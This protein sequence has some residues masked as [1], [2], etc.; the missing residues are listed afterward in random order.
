[1]SMYAIIVEGGGQRKVSEGEIITI[2]L[3]EGGEAQVGKT[4]SFDKV[5]V[6]GGRDGADTKIGL[7]YINGGRVTAEV[8]E[9]LAKGDKL[10]IQ[11]FQAKKGS[12]RRTGHRQ[13]YTN[14]KITGISG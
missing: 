6:I 14:V 2:D 13:K 8:V 12:R 5:L 10:R 11:Y 3:I 4:L 7:P 1:M 9:P